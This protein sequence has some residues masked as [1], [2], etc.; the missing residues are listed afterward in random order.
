MC[1]GPA[2]AQL[3]VAAASTAATVQQQRINQKAQERFQQDLFDENE[4]I[5]QGA[6]VTQVSQ[7]QKRQLEESEAAAQA[8][9]QNARRAIQAKGTAKVA[10]GEAGGFG[11]SYEALVSDFALQEKE[12]S[13]AVIRNTVFSQQQSR[14]DLEAARAGFQG[15]VLQF[16]P[17]PV[18]RPDYLGASLRLIGQGAQIAQEEN[19]FNQRLKTRR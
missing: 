3:L 8:I 6:F 16:L 19:R 1:S 15:R 12:F 17:Q 11:L 9:E 18:P 7:I 14:L 2:I 5:A 4:R 13:S 10:T